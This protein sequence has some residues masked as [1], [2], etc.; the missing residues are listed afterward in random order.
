MEN[1]FSLNLQRVRQLRNC[2][3]EDL[4]DLVGCSKQAI[5][6]YENGTRFPDGKMLRT[7]AHALKVEIQ[8]LISPINVDLNLTGVNYR[9]GEGLGRIEKAEIE[10]YAIRRLTNYLELE[11]LAKE[12]AK[13]ENPLLDLSVND[14]SDAERAAKYLRKRW[15]LGDGPIASV[16]KLLEDKGIRV[17]KV[18]FGAVF[19]HEGLSGWAENDTIPVIIINLRQTELAR[20]RFTL[21]HE[22]AH[23]LL[24]I[25]ADLDLDSVERIC[26]AFAGAVLIPTEVLKSEFGKNRKSILMPELRRI[27]EFYGISI[28]AIMVRARFAGLISYDTFMRWNLAKNGREDYGE[29]LGREEPERFDQLLLKCLGEGKIGT[30]KAA[31]LSGKGREEF[32]EIYNTLFFLDV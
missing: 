32:E 21:L 8:S 29:Y 16:T 7:I 18:D 3:M 28:Q 12:G 31:N 24:A 2:S 6:N 9:F 27:K 1:V 26:E 22:L 5:S 10:E 30:E 15:K 20:V 23:L 25:N 13:F 11:Q 17:L 19:K 14:T 4:A